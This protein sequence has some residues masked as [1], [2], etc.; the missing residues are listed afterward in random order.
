MENNRIK[1]RKRNVGKKGR[2]IDLKKE[3][4]WWQEKR[5]GNLKVARKNEKKTTKEKGTYWEKTKLHKE[6]NGRLEHKER[7]QVWS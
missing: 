6:G 7:M 1:C 4:K 3:K 2:E 5:K